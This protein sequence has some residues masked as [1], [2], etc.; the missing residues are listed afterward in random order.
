MKE[1]KKIYEEVLGEMLQKAEK[2]REAAYKEAVHDFIELINEKMTEHEKQASYDYQVAIEQ[3]IADKRLAGCSTGTLKNYT[4]E[5]QIFKKH[6]NK[7]LQDITDADIKLYLGHFEHLKRATIAT[8]TSILK[9]F[10]AYLMD[11]EIIQKNPMRKIKRVKEEKKQI[12][13]LTMD[14]MLRIREAAGDNLRARC[15]LEFLFETGCRVSEMVQIR[16]DQIDWLNR[17]VIVRGKGAKERTVY[18]HVNAHY[19]LKKYLNT[20]LDNS[21]YLFAPRKGKARALSTRIVQSEIKKIGEKAGLNKRLHPHMLR[22]T[23]ATHLLNKGMEISSV[24]EILGHEKLS[25]TQI[26]AR[27]TERRKKEEYIRYIA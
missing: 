5:L 12:R 23:L 21:P 10:F 15:M 19:Y 22:H 2:R 6:I 13:Y 8:K 18:F 14:E 25:T 11:E 16:L 1:I 24:A 27:I 20:R 17:S 4:L 3:F 26:Y 7:P 9:S